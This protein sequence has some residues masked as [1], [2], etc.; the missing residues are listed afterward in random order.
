MAEPR[1]LGRRG[2]YRLGRMGAPPT[3]RTPWPEVHYPTWTPRRR[4]PVSLWVLACVAGAV[5]VAAGALAGWWFLP[6]LAGLGTGLAARYGR[7]RLRVGGR[8]RRGR[9]RRCRRRGGLA[10]AP[11]GLLHRLDVHLDQVR[12]A[13]EELPLLG[14]ERG[15]GPR[16]PSPAGHRDPMRRGPGPGVRQDAAGLLP[17][18]SEDALGLCGSGQVQP[19]GPGELQLL[20]EALRLGM[21]AGHLL[22]HLVEELVDLPLVVSAEGQAELLLL[23]VHRGDPLRIARGGCFG[24]GPFLSLPR[25]RHQPP[26]VSRRSAGGP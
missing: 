13:L 6:F 9:S 23:D 1:R 18:P 4:G 14:E 10:G 17:S 21:E 5:I 12:Q 22:G 15:H 3:P 19:G 24:L 7:L 26:G 25:H 20:P 2:S 8:A 16:V 11:D